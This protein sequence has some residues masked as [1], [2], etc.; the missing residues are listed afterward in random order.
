MKC[1]VCN[2]E[3]VLPPDYV[4]LFPEPKAQAL[5]RHKATTTPWLID[6]V[7]RRGTKTLVG[8]LDGTMSGNRKGELYMYETILTI[9][10]TRRDGSRLT[11]EGNLKSVKDAWMDAQIEVDAS[12]YPSFNFE[13]LL[14]SF[15]SRKYSPTLVKVPSFSN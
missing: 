15:D 9:V 3:V 2:S 6:C 5:V 14:R 10:L 4:S 7:T 12:H 8:Y 13:Q 1:A 11:I